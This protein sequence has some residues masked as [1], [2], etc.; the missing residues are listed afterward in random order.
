MLGG[1]FLLPRISPNIS[2][3]WNEPDGNPLQDYLR[4]LDSLDP[5]ADEAL[6]L[7]SHD[8]PYRGVKPRAVELSEHHER[9]LDLAEQVCRV[10]STAIDVMN[11]M[12]QRKMDPHQTRFAVGESLAHLNFLL[13]QGRLT[14]QLG[15]DGAWR[16]VAA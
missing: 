12:F 13:D 11:A 14:R 4:F 5:I 8:R 1:D 2:V 16:Y 3:W 6:I 7:P 10:P 9:R 15:D